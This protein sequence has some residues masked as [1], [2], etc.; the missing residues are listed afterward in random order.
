MGDGR[1][2]WDLLYYPYAASDGVVPG[3]DRERKPMKSTRNAV[4]QVSDP[5]IHLTPELR[6]ALLE[7]A[8]CNLHSRTILNRID[9]IFFRAE[10]DSIRA[11]ARRVSACRLTW[12]ESKVSR[13]TVRRWIVA[14]LAHG[15]QGLYGRR[16][17]GRKALEWPSRRYVPPSPEVP[18][19][20][21]P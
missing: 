20:G 8:S 19:A 4:Q 14:F 12:R 2:W 5:E 1:E 13:K 7:M 21:Q 10:G 15:V 3:G 11:I 17:P 18:A 16:G 9:I 6:A